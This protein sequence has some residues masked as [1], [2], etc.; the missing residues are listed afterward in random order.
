MGDGRERERERERRDTWMY[1]INLSRAVALGRIFSAKTVLALVQNG[2]Q[3]RGETLGHQVLRILC[4]HYTAS[5]VSQSKESEHT[6]DKS[7]HEAQAKSNHCTLHNANTGFNE[8]IDK[9]LQGGIY[10]Q[11]IY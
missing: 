10:A 11:F 4:C 6:S 1:V 5:H 8:L 7:D 9:S 3:K 2:R